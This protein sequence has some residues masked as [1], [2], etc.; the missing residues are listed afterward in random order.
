MRRVMSKIC[1]TNGSLGCDGAR[2]R[3]P[4]RAPPAPFRRSEFG[5]QGM[6]MCER[7]R[8]RVTEGDVV[9]ATLV[10][11]L[12][13]VAPAEADDPVVRRDCRLRRFPRK[14]PRR[15]VA[16]QQVELVVVEEHHPDSYPSGR[17]K[18]GDRVA[19]VID[20]VPPP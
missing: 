1:S 10:V 16:A 12:V 9:V 7:R 3:R 13:R 4:R 8:A 6:L 11:D 15:R 20:Q 2:Q 14:L 17:R 19:R 18:H 5:V